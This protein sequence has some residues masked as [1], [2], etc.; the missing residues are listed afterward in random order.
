[1]CRRAAPR[2]G[3]S[4]GDC[5][6]E[7]RQCVSRTGARLPG[8][9][10]GT[11]VRT[12]KLS[13]HLLHAVGS[14]SRAALRHP[15]ICICDREG[16]PGPGGTPEAAATVRE[17]SWW[18]ANRQPCRPPRPA[19]RRHSHHHRHSAEVRTQGRPLTD[20]QA[21]A[22]D[23]LRPR[24]MARRARRGLV[25]REP[26]RLHAGRLGRRR[27]DVARGALGQRADG[28]QG[29]AGRRAL[30]R[31]VVLQPGYRRIAADVGRPIHPGSPHVLRRPRPHQGQPVGARR[32]AGGARPQAIGRCSSSTASSPCNTR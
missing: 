24:Q 22:E 11:Q 31:L 32:A 20:H 23:P 17:V 18:E 19:H 4:R 7:D 21:F 28:G 26:E 15:A 30:L 2:G 12:R 14:L 10:P 29:L 5:R 16:R 25:E 13:G 1:M 8:E 27:Q 6:R 3:T 9:S